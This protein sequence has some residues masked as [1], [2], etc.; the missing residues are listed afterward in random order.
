MKIQIFIDT[1]ARRSWQAYCRYPNR[2]G[3]NVSRVSTDGQTDRHAKASSRVSNAPQNYNQC[4]ADQT[5]LDTSEHQVF[6]PADLLHII[7]RQAAFHRYSKEIYDTNL[8]ICSI[9][10]VHGHGNVPKFRI[11]WSRRCLC[12]SCAFTRTKKQTQNVSRS[13]YSNLAVTIT[14]SFLFSIR[15]VSNLSFDFTC[16]W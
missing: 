12:L 14:Y 1:T 15:F 6:I 2:G 4:F 3:R 16:D 10:Y 5:K 9:V 7:L 11:C 8:R 13:T